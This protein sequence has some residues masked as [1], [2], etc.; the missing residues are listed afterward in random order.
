MRALACAL[1]LVAGAGCIGRRTAAWLPPP[2]PFGA[3]SDDIIAELIADGD[4]AW[5]TRAD[6]AQ[7]DE[8]AR[9][10]GAALRYRPTDFL[11][12]V[13]LGRVSFRRGR[14]ARGPAIAAAYSD[15]AA[16]A[17]RALTA[18]HPELAHAVATGEPPPALF[19][20]A[21]PADTAALA[22]YAE[23]LLWWAI[24]RGTPTVLAARAWIEAAALRA[25]TLERAVAWAAPDRVLGILDCELPDAGP[26][27]R[28]ALDRFES[29]VALAPAY[30]PNR[31]AYAA[32]YARRVHDPGL[33]RTLL[34]AIDHAD[35]RALPGA[36]PENLDAQRQARTMLGRR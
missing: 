3:V 7:L 31:L 36:L 21:E 4:K 12:L 16:F 24:E 32:E 25:L 10:Y 29:A 18:R 33:R 20:R 19:A 9:A 14:F 2:E 35:A 34:D 23:S 6:M 8:A 28:D 11:L 15:A 5:A 26:N 27:L 1:C 30:L 22:L 17:E 13:H